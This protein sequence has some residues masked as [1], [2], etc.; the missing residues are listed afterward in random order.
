MELDLLSL[1]GLHVQS[2]TYSLAETPQRPPPPH[3]GS[4]TRT[5]LVSQ[6]RLLLFVTSWYGGEEEYNHVA[7][8]H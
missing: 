3:M 6:D 8:K 1:F 4:Y 7:K 5:L 2:C